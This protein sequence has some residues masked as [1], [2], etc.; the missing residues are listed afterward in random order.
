VW[1]S[2]E[3]AITDRNRNELS[4]FRDVLSILMVSPETSVIAAVY[5]PSYALVRARFRLWTACGGHRVSG[6][7]RRLSESALLTLLRPTPHY[8][9]PDPL[10]APF[11][12]KPGVCL[13]R[14]LHQTLE[15]E[16]ISPETRCRSHGRSG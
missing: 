11:H 14:S 4:A 12:R 7:S 15:A 9:T 1:T 10:A 6:E 16:R 13:D 5:I 3:N 8:P 2:L